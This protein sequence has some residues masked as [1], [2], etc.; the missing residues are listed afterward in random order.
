[1]NYNVIPL[2]GGEQFE[3]F[4]VKFRDKSFMFWKKKG[5]QP[6]KEVMIVFDKKNENMEVREGTIIL[7]LKGLNDNHDLKDAILIFLDIIKNKQ[8]KFKFI[9]NNE[10]EKEFF[11]SLG[12]EIGI[13]FEIKNIDKKLKKMEEEIT[14]QKLEVGSTLTIEKNDNGVDKQITVVGNRRAAYRNNGVLTTGEEKL[15][16]LREWMKDPVK[17]LELSEMTVEERDELLTTTVMANRKEYR[18]EGANEVKAYNKAEGIAVSK[19]AHEDG[20]VNPELGITQNGVYNENKYSVVEEQQ[21]NIQVV[22]PT[23]VN[24]NISSNGVQN[25]SGSTS[26]DD[27]IEYIEEQKRNIDSDKVLYIDEEYNIYDPDISY[28]KPIGKIGENGYELDFVKNCIIRHGNFEGYIGDYKEMGKSN[29]NVYEKHKVRKLE[30]KDNN[31]AFISFPVIIFILSS[32][33]LI[34]SAILLFIVD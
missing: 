33:L 19:A 2:N 16:L 9:I 4:G 34:G 22:N 5:N 12:K 20:V 26:Y 15:T 30:K 32:L 13:S 8:I 24:S 17:A 25:T 21:G 6:I 29:S 23:V 7:S 3:L 14:N 10:N 27:S 18:L 28:E 1:M 31:A 11:E